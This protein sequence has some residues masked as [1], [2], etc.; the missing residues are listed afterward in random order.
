MDNDPAENLNTGSTP[1]QVQDASTVILLREPY[2]VFL[3][4]REIR[5]DFLGG[6]CVFPGGK[7]DAEDSDEELCPLAKGV[8]GLTAKTLLYEPELEGCTALG[9]FFAAIRELYEEA[10]ILL[11]YAADG[12]PIEF[13]DD[14]MRQRFDEYRTAIHEKRLTLKELARMECLSYAVDTL[15]PYSHWITPE[16]VKKRFDTRFFLARIPRGQKTDFDQVE[17]MGYLWREPGEILE[18]HS[19]GKIKLIPPTLKTIEELSS[20]T[21]IDKL[22]LH[23]RSNPVYPILPEPYTDGESFGIKLPHDPEYTI[24]AYRQSPS[25]QSPS[26]VVFRDGMWKTAF[27]EHGE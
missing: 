25:P 26:R 23:A 10:G 11:A 20:F 24:E 1:I 2:R 7:M 21:S 17:L 3:V 19:E 4:Q 27:R 13:G 9:L 15:L 14:M 6:V 12:S 18:Q 5:Q 8:D 16:P 22:F